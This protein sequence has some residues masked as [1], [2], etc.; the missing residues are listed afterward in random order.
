MKKTVEILASF[1]AILVAFA[2]TGCRTLEPL[3]DVRSISDNRFSCTFDSVSH[4]FIVDLPHESEGSPLIIMLP[5][6][7]NTAESFRQETRL[8]EKANGLGY[9]VVYVTGAQNPNDKTSATC[10]NHEGDENGNKDVEFLKALVSYL[11][12]TYKTDHSRC[13]AVGFSNGAFMCHR[14]ALDA[15]STFKAVVSVAGSMSESIWVKRPRNSKV[16][17]LQITGEKDDVI[18]KRSDGSARYSKNPAIE[19]VIS[20]HVSAKKLSESESLTIGNSSTITKYY[21]SK[22][23]QV[24]H[25]IVKDGRHSWSAER[26]TGI[27]TNEIILDYLNTV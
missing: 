8:H 10:W 7:G 19:D 24:W 20:Y 6:Y 15:Q 17:L 12:R 14:L 13:F 11:E 23:S 9:T 21:N 2:F 27:D 25:V 1:L 26:L 18:P 4:D 22:D 5:G 3:E 16:G